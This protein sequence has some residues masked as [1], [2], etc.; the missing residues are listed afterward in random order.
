MRNIYLNSRKVFQQVGYE[1]ND[2]EVHE[3]LTCD[4]DDQG[5]Q[6][7]TDS[8]ICQLIS[9]SKDDDLMTMIQQMRLSLSLAIVRL[10]L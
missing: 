8:E 1:V 3:W 2:E 7:L 10:L 4:I 5:V 6:M 9:E